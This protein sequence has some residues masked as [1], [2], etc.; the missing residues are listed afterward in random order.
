MRIIVDYTTMTENKA[1]R[2]AKEINDQTGKPVEICNTVG[3]ILYFRRKNYN[4][5]GMVTYAYRRT[6]K[7]C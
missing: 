5:L 1:I 3:N 4:I 2:T 6:K 7:T